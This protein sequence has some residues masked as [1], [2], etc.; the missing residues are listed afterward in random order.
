MTTLRLLAT[1][2]VLVTATGSCAAP[3]QNGGVEVRP[4]IEARLD[5]MCHYRQGDAPQACAEPDPDE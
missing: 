3:L 5:L 4:G 2:A 1:L